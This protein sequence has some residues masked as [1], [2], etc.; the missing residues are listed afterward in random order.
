MIMHM[1]RLAFVGLLP[2]VG[3][4]ISCASAKP[5]PSK[6]N[7]RPWPAS[8]VQQ[9]SLLLDAIGQVYAWHPDNSLEKIRSANQLADLD[10]LRYRYSNVRLGKL[11]SVDLTNP[12]R[13]VLFYADAQTV[14]LLHRNLVELRIVNLIDLGIDA[15]DAVAYAPND[16]LWVYSADNQKLIQVDLNGK[17][18]Y[19]SVEMSQLFGKSI[20]AKELVATPSQ[21]AMATTD[22]RILLFGPFAAYRSAL[23]RNGHNLLANEERL[24]FVEGDRWWNYTGPN[25]LLEALDV[26]PDGRRLISIRGEYVLWQKGEDWWVEEM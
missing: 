9:D 8:V 22:G 7:S 19:Q 16:G 25:T 20:R 18:V 12:L 3:L 24:L 14:V 4:L 5:T 17:P 10:T 23:L 6:S 15:A 26:A 1:L 11:Q 13:P 21:V 2:S